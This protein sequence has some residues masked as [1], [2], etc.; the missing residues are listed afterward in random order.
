MSERRKAAA[1]LNLSRQYDLFRPDQAA[2]PV[3]IIGAGGIGSPTVLLLAKMGVPDITVLDFDTVQDENRASQFFRK[4]DLAKPKV[5]ALAEQCESHADATIT[6]R[7]E[8]YVSQPLSGVVIAAVDS[9]DA[10]VAI[11]QKGVRWNPNISL[12]IDGRMGGQ[13]V[14]IFALR[15]Y[16]QAEVKRY[17]RY[18][19]STGEASDEPCTAKAIC[20]T[21]FG[22]G[23]LIAA[24]VKRW[25]TEGAADFEHAFDFGSMTYV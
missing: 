12:F 18:L 11:W 9:M 1:G 15:P 2:D 10:R 7:A 8:R 4:E 13:L 5:Q 19:C 16:D 22:V 6:A 23:A 14:R 20:Y 25:W 21:T 17:E 3:T 24:T